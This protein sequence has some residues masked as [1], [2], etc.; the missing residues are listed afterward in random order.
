MGAVIIHL[1]QQNT[2]IH[3]MEMRIRYF[4]LQVTWR[5]SVRSPSGRDGIF[6]QLSL[7]LI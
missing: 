2:Q 5:C 6:Y 4:R 3:I 1:M 7:I